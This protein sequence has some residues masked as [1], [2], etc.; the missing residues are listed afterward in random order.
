MYSGSP[1]S[2]LSDRAG[3]F[4][5]ENRGPNVVIDEEITGAESLEGF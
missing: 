2:T 4:E 5:D 1:K 3:T